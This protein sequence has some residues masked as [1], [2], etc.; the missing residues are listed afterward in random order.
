MINKDTGE[1]EWEGNLYTTKNSIGIDMT[2]EAL[3]PVETEGEEKYIVK[4]WGVTA[5]K[6]D[7]AAEA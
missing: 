3:R 5:K 2:D 4:S 1:F 6:V 7:T